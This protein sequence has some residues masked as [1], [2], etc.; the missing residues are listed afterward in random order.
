MVDGLPSGGTLHRMKARGCLV[1][2]SEDHSI[3]V[4]YHSGQIHA[5]HNRCPHVGYPLETGTIDGDIITCIWHQ[6]SFELSTGS[7]QDPEI[8]DIPTFQ[9][10]V[11]DDEVWVDPTPCLSSDAS[12]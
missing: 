7:S 1:A 3:A 2:A 8:A 12:E 11:V 5:V 10:T 9:V 4:F 6:A